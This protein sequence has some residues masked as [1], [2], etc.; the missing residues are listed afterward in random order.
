MIVDYSTARPSIPALKA[1]G[2]TAVGRYIGWDSV[3]GYSSIGK[4]ITVAEADKILSADMAIF[5][6][7]EYASDAATH[8]AP[9]GMA[10]GAL[11]MKQISDLGAPPQM[12]VYF[13]VDFDMPDYAPAL[14]DTPANAKAKLGP[15]GDY[16][17][18]IHDTPGSYE[19]GV[20]GGYY[21]VKRVLDAGL[22]TKAWQ[23][24]AWSG[25]QLDS[26]A[27]LYQTLSSAP[28]SGGDVDI[29][30]NAINVL[31]YGQWP[32]PKSP[33]PKPVLIP[34]GEEMAY[35]LNM[36]A[37][38]IAHVIPVPANVSKLTMYADSMGAAI[39]PVIR[40]GFGPAW[41]V[42]EVKPTWDIPEVVTVP[43]GE[44]RITVS[45]VDAGTVPVTIVF[46]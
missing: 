19:V 10:D 44:N 11:A 40:I 36:L 43:P 17:A 37:K 7:F 2:V 15:V 23:A 31:D 12:A 21:A 46:S 13:A 4:N 27:V 9:Q 3:P 35:I 34:N 45:R 8:G 24:M 32:R 25:G 6:A 20:Y 18:A 41:S 1:A 38:G 42:V 14:P 16:F 39:P 28:V 5:L 26:R 33:I 22:A 30:E 29:R